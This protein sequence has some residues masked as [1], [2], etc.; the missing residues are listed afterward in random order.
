MLVSIKN[1]Q[2]VKK[3]VVVSPRKNVCEYFLKILWNEGFIAGY[4]MV[5]RSRHKLEIFLKYNKEGKPAVNN[6]K[7]LSKPGQRVHY[8]ARQIWKLDSCKAF[9]VFSTNQGLK[10]INMCKKAGVG[11]EPLLSIN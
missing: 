11:G 9:M 3:R 8:S 4:R 6:L 7:F 2:M 1:G 5:P 10:S